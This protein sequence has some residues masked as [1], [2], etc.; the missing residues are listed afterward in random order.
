MKIKSCEIK[1]FGKLSDKTITLDDR[2]TVVR[3]KNESGKSTLS[4]FIKYV[5]YGY[6]GKG[7]DERSNEKHRFNRT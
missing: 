1:N 6:T 7:R 2:I 4:S 5:L 3:G